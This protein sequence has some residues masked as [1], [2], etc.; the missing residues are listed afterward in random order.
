MWS[1]G[2]S[3]KVGST[4]SPKLSQ[5]NLHL[6]HIVPYQPNPCI[7]LYELPQWMERL[8]ERRTLQLYCGGH[9][10]F[11][12]SGAGS[13]ALKSQHREHRQLDTKYVD[14]KG[15]CP[16][17]RRAQKAGFDPRLLSMRLWNSF[18]GN[19]SAQNEN[20]R[21]VAQPML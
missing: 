19:R 1:F 13:V 12:K 11:Q 18:G 17:V 14:I 5:L 21:A 16:V 4:R 10:K 8:R 15:V 3:H 2:L 7:Y 6:E 9:G 20:P